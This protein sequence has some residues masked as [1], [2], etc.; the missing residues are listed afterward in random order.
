MNGSS[1]SIDIPT[2]HPNQKG[3]V[4]DGWKEL[5][6]DVLQD[7]ELVQDVLQHVPVASPVARLASRPA[8]RITSHQNESEIFCHQH[9]SSTSL[10]NISKHHTDPSTRTPFP[11]RSLTLSHPP[12]HALTVWQSIAGLPGSARGVRRA[13]RKNSQRQATRIKGAL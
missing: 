4:E 12:M 6:Q 1:K 7:K 9:L 2:D 10:I 11:P 8:C 5:V 13:R 3:L